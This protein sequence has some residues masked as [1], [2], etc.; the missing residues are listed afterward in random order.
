MWFQILGAV[1]VVV[2]IGI[3]IVF[4]FRGKKVGKA[5][6]SLLGMMIL[7][8]FGMML[9]DRITEFKVLGIG[10]IKAA[11]AQASVDAGTIQALKTRVENQ[12]ATVDAVAAQAKNAAGLSNKAA[13]QIN[14]ADQKLADLNATLS[15]AKVTL[16]RLQ[17]DADFGNVIQQAQNDDRG[18]FDKLSLIANDQSSPMRNGLT[19][20]RTLSRMLTAKGFTKLTSNSLGQLTSSLTSYPS[21]L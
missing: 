12:S 7:V 15:A 21:V 11:T 18:A 2:A 4:L 10:T 13:S 8:G 6:A 3:Y 17:K 14:A 20:L 1:I 5:E 19:P 16:E 9:L